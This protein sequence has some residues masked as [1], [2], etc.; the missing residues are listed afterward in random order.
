LGDDLAIEA[1][2][3]HIRRQGL[4]EAAAA[5]RRR[6]SRRRHSPRHNSRIAAVKYLRKVARRTGRFPQLF[7]PGPAAREIQ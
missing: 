7:K 3:S 1:I 2:D 5:P 6:E 4:N